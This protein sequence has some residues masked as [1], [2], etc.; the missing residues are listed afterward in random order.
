M[1]DSVVL[2]IWDLA[3]LSVCGDVTCVA[4]VWE[5]LNYTSNSF[6]KLKK[7]ITV[8][9]FGT[10][11]SS[12]QNGNSSLFFQRGGTLGPIFWPWVRECSVPFSCGSWVWVFGCRYVVCVGIV[13]CVCWGCSQS[14]VGEGASRFVSVRTGGKPGFLGHFFFSSSVF[15][16]PS[17]SPERMHKGGRVG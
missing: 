13:I 9:S 7:K 8:V 1:P 11:V 3:G 2:G 5:L 14:Q 4:N 16:V 15:P 17:L 10:S 12:S 6:Y